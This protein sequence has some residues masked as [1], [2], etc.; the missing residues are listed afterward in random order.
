M[1]ERPDSQAAPPGWY[2]DPHTGLNRYWDGYHWGQTHQPAQV[3][4]TPASSALQAQAMHGDVA[5]PPD[6]AGAPLSLAEAVPSAFR[7]M[8]SVRGRASRSAFWWF[9]FFNG[10]AAFAIII[11]GETIS[12]FAYFM[13]IPMVITFV[14]LT[15]RRLHDTGRSAQFLWLY[16]LPFVGTIVL[17][18]FA[19]QAPKDPNPYGQRAAAPQ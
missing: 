18:V 6:L 16:L 4:S 9:Y 17:F 1:D 7:N 11:V 10:L 8:F 14:T 5:M 2:I 13:I 3:A 15:G 19:L 12:S